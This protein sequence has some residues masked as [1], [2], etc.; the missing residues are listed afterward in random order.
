MPSYL[1]LESLVESKLTELS[2]Y[3][4][5]PCGENNFV[6]KHSLVHDRI[7]STSN[8]VISRFVLKGKRPCLT[9]L[10][11]QHP[12]WSDRS[13]IKFIHTERHYDVAGMFK[14]RKKKQA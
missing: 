1:L 14:K 5:F 8:F 6:Q 10:D 13:L 3:S 11:T 2:E 12:E 9:Q 4:R 7:S